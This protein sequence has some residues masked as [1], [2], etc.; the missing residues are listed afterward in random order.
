MDYDGKMEGTPQ[1]D[2]GI[3]ALN[4]MKPDELRSIRHKIWPSL[5][6]LVDFAVKT[7]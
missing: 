5:A 4:W 6:K 1:T 3:S 7:G 2:E